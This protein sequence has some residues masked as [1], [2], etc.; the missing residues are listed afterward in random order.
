MA[1]EKRTRYATT[2]KR[3]ISLFGHILRR[4]ASE[5]VVTIGKINGRPGDTRWF[6]TWYG[7]ILSR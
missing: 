3:Q 1:N 7:E 4:K 2:G 6:R 5:N